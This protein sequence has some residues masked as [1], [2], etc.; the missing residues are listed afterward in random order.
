M[1]FK[2]GD[3]VK[4]ARAGGAPKGY[5]GK[6]SKRWKNGNY[7]VKIFWKKDCSDMPSPYTIISIVP[8]DLEACDC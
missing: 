7:K 6:V 5:C 8:E 2:V 1:A 3:K 4:L